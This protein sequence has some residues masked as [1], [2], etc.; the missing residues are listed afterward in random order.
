MS[1]HFKSRR[2]LKSGPGISGGILTLDNPQ[3]WLNGTNYPE[4]T[5]QALKL[6]AVYRCIAVLAD[7][8]AEMP[9]SVRDWNT[10]KD[11]PNH[12][13]GRVLWQRPNEAMTP[14]VYKRLMERNRNL[15]GNAYAYI[16]RDGNGRPVELIPLPPDAV[17]VNLNSDGQL[18]YGFA[19]P[20][21]GK[22]YALTPIQVLHYKNDSEDGMTGISTLHHAAL[23]L[24]TARAREEYDHAVYVNGGSPAGVLQTDSD[25]SKKITETDA[26]GKTRTITHRDIIR[27]EWE[28]VHG[29]AA[30]AF[31]VA[32]L[33]LGLK[34]Q[35]ISI[36]NRDA[37][38]VENKDVS[39]LDICRFFGVPPHKVYAGKQSYD[40]NEANTIDFITDTMQPI[41]TQY[42]EEDKWKLLVPD[43]VDAGLIVYR[44]MMVSLRGNS[45]ARAE[46]YTAM[47][48]IGV[49]NVDEIRGKEGEPA[50]SGGD[51]RYA[52]LNYIPLDLFRELSITRNKK[53]EEAP[54]A[55][56][57]G[58]D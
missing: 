1:I 38:F 36:T 45:T 3:G 17:S 8:I 19:H 14:F 21:T 55:G 2:A 24:A 12:Y 40:S 48:N 44:N 30:N 4:D 25:V 43:D 16:H 13:L 58:G 10:N 57:K 50:V 56:E 33:D 41:V 47:R 53:K 37:Q 28:R 35:P 22:S 39:I 49:Y 20:N 31:R 9:V 5:E 11:Q 34:Y 52:S 6:S 42:E 18:W 51:T 7:A 29:G 27:N 23:T 26:D 54:N 15:R 46:W 32:V